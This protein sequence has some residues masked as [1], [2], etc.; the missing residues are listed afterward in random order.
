MKWHYAN[1]QKVNFGRNEDRHMAIALWR[2]INQLPGPTLILIAPLSQF[3]KEIYTPGR[4]LF[5]LNHYWAEHS[6]WIGNQRRDETSIF[7][8]MFW[9]SV[10]ATWR[11]NSSTFTVAYAVGSLWINDEICY[12]FGYEAKSHEIPEVSRHTFLNE[13]E[14]QSRAISAILQEFFSG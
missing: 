1:N 3:E 8:C 13:L 2:F 4:P 5:S 6:L 14:D 9:I 10:D 11:F 7:A 12:L